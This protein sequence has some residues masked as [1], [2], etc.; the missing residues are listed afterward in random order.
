MSSGDSASATSRCPRRR[1]GWTAS[2][3]SCAS[4]GGRHELRIARAAPR[5]AAGPARDRRVSPC[6]AAAIPVRRA[7]HERRP[8]VQSRPTNA[9]LAPPRSA[10]PL[11]AGARGARHRARQAVGDAGGPAGGRD[12]RPDDGCL[13]LDARDRRRPIPSRQREAGRVRVHR[14]AAGLVPGR[15]RHV[16]HGGA[17]GRLA[18]D[19]SSGSARRTRLLFRR[20]AGQPL[21]MRSGCRWGW[22]RT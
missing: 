20:M 12:D 6:P 13:G 5:P 2:R 1:A 16:R 3:G 18:D 4:W 22:R 8:P 11:C 10:G 15:A 17:G 14:P 21:A 19:R 9:G 7:L